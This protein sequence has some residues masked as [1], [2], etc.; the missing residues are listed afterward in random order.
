MIPD[1]AFVGTS[2][3]YLMPTY[4]FLEQQGL[5][6]GNIEEQVA[7]ISAMDEQGLAA[8]VG[9]LTED[10]IVAIDDVDISSR[11]LSKEL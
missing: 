10:I 11:T 4:S 5:L 2:E 8:Q 9:I 1:N 6:V 3:S 7:L